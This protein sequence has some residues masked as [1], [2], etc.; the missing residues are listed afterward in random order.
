M[1]EQNNFK[2]IY[3]LIWKASEPDDTFKQEEF[4]C[5]IPRLMT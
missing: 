3:A 5:R 4:E 2:K 1:T